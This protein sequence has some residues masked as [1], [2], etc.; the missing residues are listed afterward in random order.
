MGVPVKEKWSGAPSLREVKGIV[1]S[2]HD[3]CW[4]VLEAAVMSGRIL[5][6]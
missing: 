5:R 4:A 3:Y 1:L 2:G 6:T